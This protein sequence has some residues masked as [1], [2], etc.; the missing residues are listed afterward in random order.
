MVNEHRG[1]VALQI[2]DAVYTLRFNCNALAALESALCAKMPK[3]I[4]AFNAKDV[5]FTDLRAMLWA[6]LRDRHAKVTVDQAGDLIDLAGFEV[7]TNAVALAFV[8][9]FP[10]ATAASVQGDRGPKEQAPPGT[11]AGSSVKRRKRASPPTDSGSTP[12]GS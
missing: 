6:A 10:E 4:E 9:G 11:G 2:G 12:L 7:V 8:R 1:E 3:I 5:G